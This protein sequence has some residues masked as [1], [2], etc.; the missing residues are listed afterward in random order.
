MQ[1]PR[2]CKIE[3]ACAKEPG[4]YAWTDVLLRRN[5]DGSG[6][7]AATDGR[8]LVTITVEGLEPDETDG[9]IPVE[10]IKRARKHPH[11]IL[12]ANG[13]VECDGVKWDRPTGEFPKYEAVMPAFKPGSEG[14]VTVALDAK[15][16]HEIADAFGEDAVSITFKVTDGKADKFAPLLV[17]PANCFKSE[18]RRAALMPIT[19]DG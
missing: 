17:L 13:H 6:T 10:A 15:Y 18:R 3:K 8:K 12:T 9:L 1:I 11:G 19:I 5:E 4:R 2:E 7:L 16:L 14:T